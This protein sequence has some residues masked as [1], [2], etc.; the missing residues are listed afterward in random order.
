MGPPL[1]KT[2]LGLQHPRN[3][4]SHKGRLPRQNHRPTPLPQKP[5]PL[6]PGPLQ[7]SQRA[8]GS[9]LWVS[10]CG[11][12]RVTVP[13]GP[14]CA[15]LGVQSTSLD[16]GARSPFYRQIEHYCPQASPF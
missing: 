11:V 12:V 8:L 1:K 6:H 14:S 2:S 7:S 13:G 3:A 16:R 5:P 15:S 4:F 10:L 9:P